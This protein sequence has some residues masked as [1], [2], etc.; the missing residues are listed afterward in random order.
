M[1]SLGNSMQDGGRPVQDTPDK[2]QDLCI[3]YCMNNLDIL[4]ASLNNVSESNDDI[5]STFSLLLGNRLMEYFLSNSLPSEDKQQ[6]VDQLTQNNQLCNEVILTRR[7][8]VSSENI[9]ELANNS[10]RRLHLSIFDDSTSEV[11]VSYEELLENNLPY[12]TK[13]SLSQKCE[14]SQMTGFLNLLCGQEVDADIETVGGNADDL[15][16]SIN[17]SGDQNR[18]KYDNPSFYEMVVSNTK[19]HGFQIRNLDGQNEGSGETVQGAEKNTEDQSDIAPN[20]KSFSYECVY[21]GMRPP[22]SAHHCYGWFYHLLTEILLRNKQIQSFCLVTVIS[23]PVKWFL[24]QP[25]IHSMKNIQSLC[26]SFNCPEQ[27]A[28]L[29]ERGIPYTKEFFSNLPLLE[30]LR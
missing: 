13:V 25:K 29:E 28:E 7:D 19:F 21:M 27:V 12:L 17:A 16:N 14:E 10:I 22:I 20:L 11:I 23:N 9:Q 4:V 30:N 3:F 26:L 2:L 6:F 18:G 15:D 5:S 1:A 8:V 24:S